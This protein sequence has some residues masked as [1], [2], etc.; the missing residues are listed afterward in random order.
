MTTDHDQCPVLVD[1]IALRHGRPVD[2]EDPEH[3]GDQRLGAHLAPDVRA[4][5]AQ[6]SVGWPTADHRS[7]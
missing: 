6:K 4:L 2:V 5:G 3:G 1:D 7:I